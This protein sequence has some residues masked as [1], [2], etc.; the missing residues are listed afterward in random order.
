MHLIN[1]ANGGGVMRAIWD[2]FLESLR[3]YA[4]SIIGAIAVLIVGWLVAK[5][6]SGIVRRGLGRTGIADPCSVHD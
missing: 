2:Q 3:T 1:V 6:V 4:P 5:I